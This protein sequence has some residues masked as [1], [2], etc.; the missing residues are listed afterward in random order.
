MES[1]DITYEQCKC[2]IIDPAFK[3]RVKSLKDLPFLIPDD[4]QILCCENLDLTSLEGCPPNVT[5]LKAQG[6]KLK[7]FD[8]HFPAG[9]IKVDVSHNNFTS[10][11]GCPPKL[12][13]LRVSNNPLETLK[14]C[15]QEM[16]SLGVSFT[17]LEDFE[18]CGPKVTDI[19]AV[20]FAPF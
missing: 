12:Q 6:N 17:H 19:T 5:E 20:R 7:A 16:M 3:G 2:I 10:L 8:R 14:G 1:K 9:L 13:H 4:T 11:E 15:G 18:G